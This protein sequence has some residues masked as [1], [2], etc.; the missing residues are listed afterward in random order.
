MDVRVSASESS[1]TAMAMA[2]VL[3]D[4]NLEEAKAPDFIAVHMSAAHDSA[5]VQCMLRATG[6]GALHG[7]T[8]CLGVMTNAGLASREGAGLGVFA[9]WDPEGDYGSAMADLSEDARTAAKD[10]IQKALQ[11]AD[12][13]G[14]IPDLVWLT[15]APGQE[16]DIIEGLQEILGDG[17]PIVGGSAAD[18]TIAGEWGVFD[19]EATR[20]NGVMVSVLFPS[21]PL[22]SAYQS[23]YAPSELQGKVTAAE[24]RRLIEIDGRPAAA[25]YS[26]WTGLTLDLQPHDDPKM[27]LGES[28]LMP[29]GREASLVA[30]VPFYLL[31]HPAYANPD[32]SIDLFS[33][34]AVGENITLMQ[35]AVESLTA[36]AGKVASMACEKGRLQPNDV[37]GALVV[38]CGGCMLAVREHMARVAQ[39]IDE[40]LNGAPFLGVFTFGEQGPV[41]DS[42]NRHGNLMIS[43]V[44]FAK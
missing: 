9:I 27:I 15:A 10:A 2:E 30:D 24:G 16:E 41:I 6:V 42:Q 19:S 31:S 43:C 28:T 37:A 29:L 32:G 20:T 21:R 35:G 3:A 8:S 22:F 34:I 44:S 13:S 7:G 40:A 33:E 26:E 12:R 11:A 36:R 18:N 25:V 23:G 5:V 1:D 4:L 38:Y 14:E 39:G 17:V